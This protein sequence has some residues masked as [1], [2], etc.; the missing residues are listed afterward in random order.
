MW[1]GYTDGRPWRGNQV[2]MGPVLIHGYSESGRDVVGG[3][4]PCV[5]NRSI[6]ILLYYG[7][8]GR[9]WTSEITKNRGGLTPRSNN[10]K[11]PSC[12]YEAIAIYLK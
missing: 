6:I 1:K 5:L 12:S 11:Y 2:W 10:T 4:V 8:Y 9:T 3:I 7:N